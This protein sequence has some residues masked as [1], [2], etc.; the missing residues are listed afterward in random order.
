MA[1]CNVFAYSNAT[2]AGSKTYICCKSYYWNNFDS[3]WVEQVQINHKS[4]TCFDAYA[5]PSNACL[6]TTKVLTVMQP[7]VKFS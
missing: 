4:K 7:I 1:M 5:Q 3:L 2:I 6:A